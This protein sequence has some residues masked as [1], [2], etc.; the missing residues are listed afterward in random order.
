MPLIIFVYSSFN[1][2]VN[3]PKKKEN[4]LCVPAISLREL[5]IREAHEVV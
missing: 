2:S 3:L 5:L 4:R 1:I